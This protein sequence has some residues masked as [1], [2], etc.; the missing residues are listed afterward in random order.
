M[1]VLRKIKDKLKKAI[2]KGKEKKAAVKSALKK[3]SIKKPEFQQ[4]RKEILGTQ[5]TAVGK[6]KFFTPETPRVTAKILQELPQM[7]GT[8]K[9]VLQARDA[10]WLHTYWEIT[11]QTI[12]ALKDKLKDAYYAARMILRVYDVSHINFN[13]SNAHSFFDIE[14]NNASSWYINAGP[15]RSWCV[16]IGLKLASGEYIMI[17]RSNI[18]HTPLEGP[19]W[20]TDEEWMI[21]EDMFARLYG[22][23]FGFGRTSPIGKV[24]VERFKQAV[25]SASGG[26]ASMASPVKKVPKQRKFWMVVNTELIVY[27]ATEPDAKVTV[28]GE[29][30]TLR[31]DGTFSLRYA[32]PDGKQVI[33]VEGTSSDE[34]ETIT[35][36]PIVSKETKHH[37]I[38][39]ELAK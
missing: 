8:D 25:S 2:Q 33:P 15:G 23:G 35:I 30:I 11:H 21:P 14:I 37:S 5:E 17:A 27:G 1:A 24:W 22:M 38:N 9:I 36:T 34:V 26:I 29:H 3:K 13:G 31:P 19:S 28:Q 4:A 16:E 32:L 18:A 12:N 20:V 6:S 39:R 7:Y 10:W